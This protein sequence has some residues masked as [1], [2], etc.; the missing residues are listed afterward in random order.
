MLLEVGKK[1]SAKQKF[2]IGKDVKAVHV[3]KGYEAECREIRG[4]KMLY[5]RGRYLTDTV[6]GK[7]FEE[8]EV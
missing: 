5:L 7:Y 4:V 8:S 3:A 2:V 1:Y 6:Y